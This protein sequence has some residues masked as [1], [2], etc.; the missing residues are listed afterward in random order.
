MNTDA[1]IRTHIYADAG[2]VANAARILATESTL[3][4]HVTV[5]GGNPLE[6]EVTSE[7]PFACWGSG[8]QALWLLL[9]SLVYSAEKV[10]IYSVLSRLDQNN[11]RV[12][13]RALTTMCGTG[14]LPEH[15][16]TA[17]TA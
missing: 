16:A 2:P 17:V 4:E 6:V 8:T 9:S 15:Y 11:T 10:S 3:A 14:P 12:V 1:D 13:S 7:I 5:H